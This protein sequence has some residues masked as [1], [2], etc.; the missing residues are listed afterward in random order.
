MT[1]TFDGNLKLFICNPGTIE[2]N[3]TELYSMWK[4][5]VQSGQGINYL[6]MFEAIGGQPL[7][8]GLFAGQTYF[9][10]NGWKIKPQQANHKLTILGNLY[11][12]DGSAVTISSP[13][14]TVEVALATSAQAQ[15]ISTSGGSGITLAQIEASTVLAKQAE[16]LLLVDRLTS[17]RA[18]KLDRDLA[19]AADADRYKANVSGLASQLTV[20]ELKAL[21]EEVHLLHGLK[22]GAPLVVSDTQRS[23]GHVVQAVDTNE[24]RTVVTRNS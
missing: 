17:A 6:P 18:A 1:G 14:F 16:L 19:H 13:G 7:P 24:Q 3:V 21:I 22:V 15:G 11:S 12:S 2:L 5:W 9:L 10:I 20:A 8:G 23:A 4:Q